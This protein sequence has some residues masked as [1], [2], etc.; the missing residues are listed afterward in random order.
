MP[1]STSKRTIGATVSDAGVI[2]ASGAE[3]DPISRIE[4][5]LGVKLATDGDYVT[6]ANVHGNLWRGFENFLLGRDV[7]SAGNGSPM[8]RKGAVRAADR[9]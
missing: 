3:V 2:T 6:E 8:A 4:G 7:Q 5:H 1:S 9:A